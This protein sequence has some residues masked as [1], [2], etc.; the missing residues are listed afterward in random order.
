M[1]ALGMQGF[2]GDR[3]AIRTDQPARAAASATTPVPQN[4][5]TNTPDCA[6]GS[7]KKGVITSISR[8]LEPM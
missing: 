3:A 2:R 7:P 5:S 8:V 1:R 6:L 4:A